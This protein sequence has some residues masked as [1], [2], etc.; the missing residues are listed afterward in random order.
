MA[1]VTCARYQFAHR[2]ESR[3]FARTKEKAG[4]V[5]PTS[6]SFLLRL[7]WFSEP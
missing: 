3:P 4:D 2:F 1:R 6:L 7:A 5:L